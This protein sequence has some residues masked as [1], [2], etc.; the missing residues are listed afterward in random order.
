MSAANDKAPK[1]ATGLVVEFV[2][3]NKGKANGPNI[4]LAWAGAMHTTTG[5][6][7]GPIGMVFTD[8]VPYVVL[9]L[10][11][12]NVPQ[13]DDP[14]MEGLSAV[15]FN[16]IRVSAITT[17]AKKKREPRDKLPKFFNY[18]LLKLSDAS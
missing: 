6:S 2:S 4:N 15:I 12:D 10:E 3:L 17:N 16:V 13:A 14:G 18:I 11:A 9:E 7:Y 5:A 1:E 8:Q